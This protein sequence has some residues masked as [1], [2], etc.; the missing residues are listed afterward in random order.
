MGPPGL[1]EPA[2]ISALLFFPARQL[3]LMPAGYTGR[4]AA[5]ARKAPPVGRPETLLRDAGVGLHMDLRLCRWPFGVTKRAGKVEAL[6]QTPPGASRP[7]TCFS[8][9]RPVQGGSP[10]AGLGGAAQR[11]RRPAWVVG[12]GSGRESPALLPAGPLRKAAPESTTPRRIGYPGPCRASRPRTEWNRCRGGGGA[13][14]RPAPPPAVRTASPTA[15]KPDGIA[16]RAPVRRQGPED[17]GAAPRDRPRPVGCRGPSRRRGAVSSRGRAGRSDLHRHGVPHGAAAGGERHPGAARLRRRPGALRADRARPAL[18]PDRRRH[19]ACH[20]VRGQGARAADGLHRAPARLRP[21]V[22]P[23]GAVRPQAGGASRGGL[24]AGTPPL[25]R[26]K[27]SGGGA[28]AAPAAD[29]VRHGRA[30]R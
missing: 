12:R 15:W 21:G 26:A 8:S 7:W 16:H 17:D 6:P 18:P 22:A 23:A 10:L 27:T 20:R 9:V 3:T 13:G 1:K 24:R 11:F 29:A 19:R 5:G 14:L 4:L 2:R 25:R 28:A 30:G